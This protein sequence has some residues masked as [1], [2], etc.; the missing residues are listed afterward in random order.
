MTPN[1]N[2]TVNL[3]CIDHKIFKLDFIKSEIYF[4][5]YTLNSTTIVLNLIPFINFIFN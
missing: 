3:V 1:K 2:K 4:N 5:I